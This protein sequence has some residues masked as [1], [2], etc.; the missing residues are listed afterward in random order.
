MHPVPLYLSISGHLKPYGS[1]TLGYRERLS[2][3]AT[4]YLSPLNLLTSRSRRLIFSIRGSDG[5]GG[6]YGTIWF[7]GVGAK[8]TAGRRLSSDLFLVVIHRFRIPSKPPI[9]IPNDTKEPT[10]GA[11]KIELQSPCIHAKPVTHHWYHTFKPYS[12]HCQLI[13]DGSRN[14][15][16]KPYC[17]HATSFAWFIYYCFFAITP[18]TH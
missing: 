14:T 8:Y 5:C 2:R 11:R 9:S 17:I 6:T 13:V 16:S 4:S 1:L 15:K 12:N 10:G 7:M 18:V 3:S